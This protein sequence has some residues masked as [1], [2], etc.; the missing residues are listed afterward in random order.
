MELQS[1][2]TQTLYSQL[3]EEA[4]AYGVLIFE[5]GVVG[6]PYIN[7]ARG[8]RY[9]YWQI[10][11]P[12]GRFKRKSI[13]VESDATTAMISSLLERKKTAEDAIAGLR[14]TT[15]A[16]VGSGGMSVEPAHFKVLE[17]LARCGL[18]SKGVVVV[19]S[20]AFAG[21]GN[22]LGVRWG[23]S[24]K[25]TDMDFARPTGIS[26]AIPDSGETIRVPEVM[27]ELDDSFFEVP[28]LNLKHPS[29][30][31][32]SRKT[33]VKIDFLTTQKTL[34]DDTPH[35]FPDLSIAAEPLKFMDYLIGGQL[36][37]GLLV[38]SYAIPV[39]LPDPARFAL[40]KL[41][42]AQERTASFQTKVEKDIA[43]ASE[44]VEALVE[45]G[46]RDDLELAHTALLALPYGSPKASLQKSAER[47]RGVAKQ[48]VLA[49][50]AG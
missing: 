29:T 24:L 44:V 9:V 41:V 36:S 14:A 11:L 32:M 49:M 45:T 19:G 40:H 25:T 22:S 42:V 48:T 31:M 21:I 3:L 8:K 26:L 20:H 2:V 34:D 33:K 13:G 18:F 27:K 1:A 6:S 7:T 4:M 16:F 37:Q 28:R 12:D 30:S 17:W 5:N 43:Q 35:Y 10:K 15:R 38:G 47:M 23:S 39:T 50:L 46:R